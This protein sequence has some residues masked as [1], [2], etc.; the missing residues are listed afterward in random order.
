M[1]QYPADGKC[2]C[3]TFAFL[4][5]F[6]LRFRLSHSIFFAYERHSCGGDMLEDSHKKTIVKLN[7]MLDV[8][9]KMIFGAV[10]CEQR[11]ARA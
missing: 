6:A 8:V 4:V 7:P 10:G 9:F 1:A 11:L 3:R 2:P 5:L